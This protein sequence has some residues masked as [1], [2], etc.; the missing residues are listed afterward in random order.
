MIF[1][2]EA[3]QANKG[4]ALILHYGTAGKPR[5]VVIDGGPSGVYSASLRPR[6]KQLHKKW[7]GDGDNKLSLEMVMVSHIDDDH[8]EGIIDWVREIEKDKA[9]PC[10]WKHFWYNSFDDVLGNSAEELRGRAASLDLTPPATVMPPLFDQ[11]M[12][13]IASIRQGRELRTR[14][15]ALDI[16]INTGFDNLIMQEAG[17]SAPVELGELKLYVIGPMEDRLEALQRKWDQHVRANPDPVVLAAFLDESIPNLSSIVVV[18]EFDGKRMLL[19]GDARGDDILE[20]LKAAEFLNRRGAAHFDLIKIPHHGS[21]RNVSPEWLQR[22]TADHYVISANGEHK[23]PDADVIRWIC[24]ARKSKP[25]T[26]YMTNEEMVVGDEDVGKAV[27]DAL[28]A[29]PDP[30][31]RVIFRKPAALSVK[32]ELRDEITY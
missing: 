14:V 5:F 6:L 1:T 21:N 25:Y 12:A 8:I 28:A 13:V 3:L 23:N 17:A 24:A 20:G 26:I 11:A 19:T 18:A 7:K 15:D 9:V 27:R 10:R 31:R 29:F 30:K 2:L 16:P 32:A 4:D 22:I